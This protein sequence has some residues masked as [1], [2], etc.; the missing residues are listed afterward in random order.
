[1]HIRTVALDNFKSHE[2]SAVCFAPGTNAVCGPN[3][4]GKTSLVQAIALALFD[5]C[6]G[7][8]GDYV[9]KG[10]ASAE[11]RVT[12]DSHADGRTYEVTR[13]IRR[14]GATADWSA[15]DVEGEQSVVSGSTD[16]LAWLREHL[17]VKQE[18]K[19]ADLF[20]DA[21]G[22]PQGQLTAA[23][24]DT[25]AP[26]QKRF[27]ALLRL[28]EFQTAFDTLR[29]TE[30]LSKEQITDAEK[31]IAGLEGET[32]SLPDQERQAE[33]LK[34]EIEE[35]TKTLAQCNTAVKTLTKQEA[36]YAA[37]E[38]RLRRQE[39]CR[40]RLQT[41]QTVRAERLKHARNA[42]A[43]A[44][45]ASQ[46]L[47]A[48]RVGYESYEKAQNEQSL[49]NGRLQERATLVSR[50]T[51]WTTKH[52][53]AQT[54][55]DGLE[56]Q[57]QKMVEAEAKAQQVEPS[58]A[59]QDQLEEAVQEA[60][61]AVEQARAEK[62]VAEE[63][64]RHSAEGLCPFLHETCRNLAATGRT[65]TQFFDARLDELQTNLANAEN[66]LR[67]CRTEL[68]AL[69][70]PR[71]QLAVAQSQMQE[72]EAVETGIGCEQKE[73]TRCKEALAT[74]D[75]QLDAYADLDTRLLR[76]K[77]DKERYAQDHDDYLACKPLADNQDDCRAAEDRAKS[78]LERVQCAL[79]ARQDRRAQATAAYDSAAHAQVSASL[80]E[81]KTERAATAADLKSRQEQLERS[82]KVLEDLRAKAKE[83]ATVQTEH[84]RLVADHRHLTEIRKAIK[85]AGPRVNEVLVQ[86]ISQAAARLFQAL[87]GDAQVG[88]E[89]TPNYE[90]L[91]TRDG[92]ETTLHTA[93]GSERVAA[94]LAVRLALLQSLGDIRIAFFDEPTIH[95]DA[96]R[97]EKLVRQ[98]LALPFF[99]QIVVISHDD[100]FE[101]HTDHVIRLSATNGRSDVL[102]A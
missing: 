31:R 61:R 69:G 2:H 84:A 51:P 34:G 29:E 12:F 94:S 91:L 42:Y 50:K 4:A 87:I 102:P 92:Q 16:V 46:K 99:R 48:C 63:G 76:Y 56:A 52:A 98:L 14:N 1:M 53:Q 54:R 7:R 8:I 5:H 23:F 86:R 22:V 74:I 68:K 43:Q 55:F 65:L 73:I 90:I 45:Q 101:A 62:K 35:L 11:I 41:W 3:Y 38:A 75:R 93:A 25:A 100:A 6:E 72:R 77:Q 20:Q 33:T 21:V 27:N 30:N 28:D 70:D 85:Q 37:A 40:N 59:R 88:L 81:V 10:A 95:L 44:E 26:R 60:Q 32:R 57:L 89:W 47:A 39:A 19:L 82:A 78:A 80:T 96:V 79:Q 66:Y 24:M 83:L 58:A 71:T 64:S 49:L 67:T 97:R 15:R 17:G 9:R 36:E 13:R 18:V